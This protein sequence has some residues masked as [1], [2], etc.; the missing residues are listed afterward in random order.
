MVS[1]WVEPPPRPR[2]VDET[3]S[4]DPDAP[5]FDL[6]KRQVGKKPPTTQKKVFVTRMGHP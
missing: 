5:S 4:Y 3:P 6:M 2:Q 1:K